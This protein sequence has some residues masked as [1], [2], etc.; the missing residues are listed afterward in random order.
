MLTGHPSFELNPGIIGTSTE[1]DYYRPSRYRLVRSC[2][3]IADRDRHPQHNVESH[4]Q[5]RLHLQSPD[6][7][8]TQR[9][10]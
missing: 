3:R 6:K 10:T 2:R 4:R 8:A 9:V 5:S 1:P 7:M